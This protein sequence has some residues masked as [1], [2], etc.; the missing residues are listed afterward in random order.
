MAKYYSFGDC[1]DRVHDALT[2]GSECT[3]FELLFDFLNAFL[4]AIQ[5]VRERRLQERLVLLVAARRLVCVSALDY[6]RIKKF[7]CLVKGPDRKQTGTGFPIEFP[8]KSPTNV[9]SDGGN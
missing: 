1:D 6:T 9:I 5:F 3:S 2:Q 7:N 4:N 8:P